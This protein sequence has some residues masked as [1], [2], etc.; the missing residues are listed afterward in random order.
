MTP[1]ATAAFDKLLADC[2][3]EIKRGDQLREQW[4]LQQLQIQNIALQFSLIMQ[5]EAATTIALLFTPMPPESKI[6][7]FLRTLRASVVK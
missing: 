5:R 4:R 6:K 2:D 7:K 1:D 3:A